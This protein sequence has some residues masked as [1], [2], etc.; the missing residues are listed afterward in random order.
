[1]S[2]FIATTLDDALKRQ[3][4]PR[5]PSFRLI[6]VKG[7]GLHPGTDLDRPRALD[8]ED[9]EALVPPRPPKR[10]MLRPDVSRRPTLRVVA[11]GPGHLD[12]DTLSQPS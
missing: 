6:T 4:P 5:P 3:T 1:M 8:A 2:A 12:V 7:G 11:P 9:D 10:L